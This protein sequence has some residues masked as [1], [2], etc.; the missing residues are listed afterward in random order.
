ME[1]TLGCASLR[2]PDTPAVLRSSLPGA[3]AVIL[4]VAV[5]LAG[6]APALADR[7]HVVAKGD[8][9]SALA[10]EYGV[11]E[12]T[13]RAVNGLA[14]N[15][16]LRLGAELRI[17]PSG[18][19]VVEPG[20]TLA[21]LARRHGLTLSDLRSA[22]K[23]KGDAR[24]RAGDRL[25]LPGAQLTAI[26][27]QGAATRAVR[28]GR[29][30]PGRL[31]PVEF[32]RPPARKAVR[33]RLLDRRGRVAESARSE[34]GRLMKPRKTQR[35][36]RVTRPERRLVALLAEVARHFGGKPVHVI[37]GFRPVAGFTRATSRHTKG[38]AIDFRIPGVSLEAV[39]DFART[40]PGAGVGY[41]PRSRF[42]HLDAREERAYWID[43]SGPGEAPRY[44]KRA[45]LLAVE[46]GLEAAEEDETADVAEAEGAHALLDESA[47]T[48][49]PAQD[50]PA[51]APSP[52]SS[53]D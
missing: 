42:I 37:S 9:V 2:G 1:V 29:A 36:V 47:D 5:A 44:A 18:T 20:D 33:I 53:E 16:A 23:L 17:P 6:A 24:I 25:V 43:W 35:R 7:S 39:R 48:G 31:G 46:S 21:S 13:L 27:P 30:E 10:R 11:P 52:A 26:A 32:V 28:G 50:E 8:T 40:L 34:L 45:Q 22:N 38:A 51:S 15:Q 49:V 19:L 3:R 41:Y 14:K 4:A 12:R